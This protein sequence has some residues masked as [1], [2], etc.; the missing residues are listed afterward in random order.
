[1]KDMHPHLVRGV[2]AQFP[3]FVASP[4]EQEYGRLVDR[5]LGSPQFGER[6]GR[7]WLDVVRYAET[8]GYERDEF[9]KFIWRYRDYVIDAL[10]RDLP[11]D[12]FIVEQLAGDE[13]EGWNA[14]TQ[15]PT[16]F[17]SLGTFDTIAADKEVARYDTTHTFVL[18]AAMDAFYKSKEGP[19]ADLW[20]MVRP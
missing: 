9:K 8:K 12:R 19:D 3:S 13:I 18:A 17:L 1:M 10:N 14:R 15:I 2:Y 5:L 4:S 6:W 20:S 7:H 16:T 11:F